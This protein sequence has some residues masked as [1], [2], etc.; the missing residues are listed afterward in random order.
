VRELVEKGDVSP[1]LNVENI[2]PDWM[3]AL[4]IDDTKVQDIK[5][6][7]LK[8]ASGYNTPTGVQNASGS[9]LTR[10]GEKGEGPGDDVQMHDKV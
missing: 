6:Q 4:Q 5:M 2:D 10:D 3:K 7:R 1:Y 8:D 9:V